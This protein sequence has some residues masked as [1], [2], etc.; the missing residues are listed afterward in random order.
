MKV[1]FLLGRLIFGGYFLYNGI[2][3]FKQRKSYAEYAKS[4]NVPKAELAVLATGVAL[5]IGG[6][7]IMLGVKPKLGTLAVLGFLAS[8]TPKMHD[9]WHVE[10]PSQRMAEMT[11]FTKNV[12]L[13]GAALALMG[14][15][16]PWPAS[17]PVAQPKRYWERIAA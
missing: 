13:A 16:E 17:V 15:E 10:E 12:A 1:P 11:N 5:I 4:K 14:V 8:V 9:F 7:S 6:A 2:N 3:H